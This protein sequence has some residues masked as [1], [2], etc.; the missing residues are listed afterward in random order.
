MTHPILNCKQLQERLPDEHLIVLHV[1]QNAGQLDKDELQIPGARIF[2]LDAFSDL[3]SPF[4]NT[5]PSATQFQA[6]CQKLGINQTSTIV[7]YDKPGIYLSPRVWWMFKTMGHEHVYVLDGGLPAW[8][9]Q[10]YDTEPIQKRTYSP[11]DFQAHFD[12]HQVKDFAFILSNLQEKHALVI[13]ARSAGR[14][15]GTAPEP[16]ENLRSGH[17]PISVNIPYTGVLKDG[18]FRPL[19]ELT[20]LLEPLQHEKRPLVFTC[21]SGVTAC[22][23]LLACEMVLPHEKA[24]YDGSWTEWATKQGLVIHQH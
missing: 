20:Q 15:A 9:E 24:I 22:I 12:Q 13:D 21:G 10:G 4:P 18:H 1:C 16:R 7:V 3:Q 8:L 6:E 14:F 19:N 5:L 2:D 23:V 17:I 11:G